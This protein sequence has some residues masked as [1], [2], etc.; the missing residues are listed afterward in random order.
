MLNRKIAF[1]SIFA[2]SH[3]TIGGRVFALG[4]L[5][6]FKDLNSYFDELKIAASNG[7]MME[8]FG[9]KESGTLPKIPMNCKESSK[10]EAIEAAT[11]WIQ[12]VEGELNRDLET[13]FSM[14]GSAREQLAQWIAADHYRV[15]YGSWSHDR[16][17]SRYL[18]LT[19]NG[20]GKSIVFEVG[21]ED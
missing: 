12:G 6:K 21:F 16:S 13:R 10:A 18:F 2:L 1:L 14:P 15:C 9:V 11:S 20:N 7:S 3:W 4:E 8:Y 19:P 17:I 5:E